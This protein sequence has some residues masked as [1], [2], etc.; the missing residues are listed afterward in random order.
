MQKPSLHSLRLMRLNEYQLENDNCVGK[1]RENEN[2]GH[3]EDLAG[4]MNVDSSTPIANRELENR[5]PPITMP[6]PIFDAQQ[7]QRDSEAQRLLKS[8]PNNYLFS[9]AYGLWLYLSL[10]ILSLILT[11]TVS[12]TEYGNYAA[13]MTA[14]NTITFIVALGIEDALVTFVPRVSVEHGKAAAGHLIRQL[15]VL[16]ITVLAGCAC[17]IISGLPV[18]PWLVSLLPIEG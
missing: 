3:A 14:M 15:L 9:Q 8:T 4:S 18:S 1:G 11:H 2:V 17:I 13:I 6:L 5:E 16:R 12:T 7:A 10:F